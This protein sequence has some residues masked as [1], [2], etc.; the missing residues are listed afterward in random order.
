MRPHED[1]DSA[2]ILTVLDHPNLESSNLSGMICKE[3]EPLSEEQE[4]DLDC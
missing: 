3:R 1:M 4:T 2:M